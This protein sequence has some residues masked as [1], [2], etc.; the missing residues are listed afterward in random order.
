MTDPQGLQHAIAS[1]SPLGPAHTGRS[2]EARMK[3]TNELMEN[4]TIQDD[5]PNYPLLGSGNTN[6]SGE[7]ILNLFH[8]LWLN[9][10]LLNLKSLLLRLLLL[11]NHRIHLLKQELEF[12]KNTQGSRTHATI[13]DIIDITYIKTTKSKTITTTT[14]TIYAECYSQQG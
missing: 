1:Y 9:V 7:D 4:V 14:L 3:E 2:D 10:P 11:L 6:R 13:E 5:N 12:L 8:N